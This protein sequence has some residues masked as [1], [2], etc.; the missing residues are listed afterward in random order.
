MLGKVTVSP[1]DQRV[2]DMLSTKVI[3]IL[4]KRSAKVVCTRSPSL[5]LS[6]TPELVSG[7]VTGGPHGQRQCYTAVTT[8]V[9]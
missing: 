7:K 3:G 4:D 8:D 5:V 6:Y 9:Q 1:N 2:L